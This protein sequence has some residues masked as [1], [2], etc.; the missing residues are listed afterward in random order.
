MI[1]YIKLLHLAA[2]KSMMFDMAVLLE[3]VSVQAT[4][5]PLANGR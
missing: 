5:P 3:L 4:F 2:Y 1:A